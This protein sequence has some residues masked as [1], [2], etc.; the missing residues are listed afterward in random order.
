V[1]Y[2]NLWTLKEL[3]SSVNANAAQIAPGEWVPARPLGF[4]SFPSRVRC[5][6]LVFTGRAD[7]L[8][9]PGQ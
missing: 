4:P 1:S 3:L 2:P 7:A 8:L 9:W 5:A 6:W